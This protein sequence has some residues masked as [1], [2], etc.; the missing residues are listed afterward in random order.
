MNVDLSTQFRPIEGLFDLQLVNS[1]SVLT[2]TI[3]QYNVNNKQHEIPWNTQNGTC[4]YMY[5]WVG[6]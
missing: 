1:K 6:E 3:T 4:M 2:Y 5:I